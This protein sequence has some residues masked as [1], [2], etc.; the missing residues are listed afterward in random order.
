MQRRTKKLIIPIISGVSGY[1]AQTEAK[2]FIADDGA[3]GFG[4]ANGGHL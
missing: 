1:V 4:A 3:I 2:H